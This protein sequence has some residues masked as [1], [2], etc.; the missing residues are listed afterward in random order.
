MSGYVQ[1]QI[2][3]HAVYIFRHIELDERE[4][5]KN[6]RTGVIKILNLEFHCFDF[7][8]FETFS[9]FFPVLK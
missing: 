3:K 2:I 5:E 1:V 6:S 9:F 8:Q 7:V 4:G